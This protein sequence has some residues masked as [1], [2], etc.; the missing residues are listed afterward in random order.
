M[1][2]V[3]INPLFSLRIEN[4]FS[5]VES[6]NSL[7]FSPYIV[8]LLYFSA[9]SFCLLSYYK[10]MLSTKLVFGHIFYSNLFTLDGAI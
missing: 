10:D 9:L 1:I 5:T 2:D 6:I 7:S 4:M 8:L 3:V